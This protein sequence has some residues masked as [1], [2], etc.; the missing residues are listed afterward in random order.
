MAGQWHD[1]SSGIH[2]VQEGSVEKMLARQARHVEETVAKHD[3]L[4]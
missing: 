3:M 1:I 4:L 2:M